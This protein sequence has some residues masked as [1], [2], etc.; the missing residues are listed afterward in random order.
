MDNSGK[1][2]TF[3]PLTPEEMKKEGTAGRDVGCYGTITCSDGTQLTC[4]SPYPSSCSDIY[5]NGVLV[6][7][8]CNGH[9]QRCTSGTGGGSGGKEANDHRPINGSLL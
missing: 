1:T 3:I 7:I 2:P 9:S 6:G 8:T 5:E 4:T